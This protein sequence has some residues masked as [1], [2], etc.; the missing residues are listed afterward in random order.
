[1]ETCCIFFFAMII[2]RTVLVL[3][4][5]LCG[6]VFVKKIILIAIWS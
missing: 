1:M 2:K 4:E 5:G 3:F 6:N